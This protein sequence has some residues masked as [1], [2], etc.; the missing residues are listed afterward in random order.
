MK[1]ATLLA[2]APGQLVLVSI[3]A[4]VKGATSRVD[5]GHVAASCFNPRPREGGDTA[6]SALPADSRV[7]S[8][9][10][11]VKGATRPLAGN[12]PFLRVSIHAPVKGATRVRAASRRSRGVSI[13][14]PVKGATSDV[15][16]LNPIEL[17]QST[18]P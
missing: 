4:P 8:I 10:A 12:L 1:G 14:A 17:F 11:P 9:H 18:P 6:N 16:T 2:A 5:V 13:H 15:S 7:V 3:H